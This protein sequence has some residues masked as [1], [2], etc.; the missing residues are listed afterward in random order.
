MLSFSLALQPTTAD[1]AAE[2]VPSRS[3]TLFLKTSPDK[4][5]QRNDNANLKV[6]RGPLNLP[7]WLDYNT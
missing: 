3:T 6:G 5:W 1:D 2:A 4:T 7:I